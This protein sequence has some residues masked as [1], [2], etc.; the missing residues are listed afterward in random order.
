[1]N[2]GGYFCYLNQA[3]YVN[4]VAAGLSTTT[5]TR[6][7][8]RRAQSPS[9]GPVEHQLGAPRRPLG[10]PGRRGAVDLHRRLVDARA[11]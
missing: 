5:E 8:L 10:E 3:H 9:D 6:D 7:R 1:M 11:L 2:L 4:G